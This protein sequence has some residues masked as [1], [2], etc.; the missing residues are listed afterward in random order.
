MRIDH[1]VKTPPYKKPDP[2]ARSRPG[3][4]VPEAEVP[5]AVTAA[6]VDDGVVQL[7]LAQDGIWK[8]AAAT[9]SADTTGQTTPAFSE[10]FPRLSRLYH[11]LLRVYSA[12]GLTDAFG[13]ARGVLLDLYT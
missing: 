3:F 5:E 12:A 8:V 2:N 11:S 10:V 6:P 13:H 1:F 7:T 9:P 4:H